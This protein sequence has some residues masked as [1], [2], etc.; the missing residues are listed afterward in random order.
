M[1]QA[2]IPGAGRP[3]AQRL[4]HAVFISYASDD[5]N[6]ADS[7]CAA[8]E[9]NAVRCWIAPRDVQGGRAYSGQI[10][11]AIREARILLLILTEA[12][13]RSKHVLREVERAAHCQNRL[14]TFRIEAISPGDDLAYFLGADHWIDGFRP[15]APSEPF[16]T[17]IQ[18][19]RA[20][21]QRGDGDLQKKS[22]AAAEPLLLAPDPDG[23]NAETYLVEYT[24]Y[25]VDLTQWTEATLGPVVVTRTDDVRKVS[26]TTADYV[27]PF[28]T[29]GKNI[30]CKPISFSSRPKFVGPK[31]DPDR[32]GIHYDY[33]LPIGHQA[34]GHREMAS[35]RFTFPSG[36]IDPQKEWW[37]SRVAYPSKTIS[38]V[39]RFPANKPAKNMSVS[40]KRGDEA[41][42]PINDNL[43]N[44]SDGGR[45]VQWVGINEKSN[46]RIHFE[47]DW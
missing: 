32:K 10:T 33:V 2:E 18:S 8:L 45:I 47:W 34:A 26:N 40:R 19:I 38:V 3:Q 1:N 20:L 28:F 16:S 41:A 15:F 14:L 24:S 12:S 13:N 7:V 11:Q 36:F 43:A 30:E 21:L 46:S 37:A 9:A 23:L 29:T 42:Q 44:L 22:P 4:R 31:N 39:F 27:I 25:L 35:S 5:K 6:V 17:L